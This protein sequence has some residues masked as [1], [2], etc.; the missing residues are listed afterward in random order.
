[1]TRNRRRKL[2]T[3]AAAATSD[4]RFTQARRR[5]LEAPGAS[6]RT[7]RG[8]IGICPTCGQPAYDSTRGASHFA[9]QDGAV[10]CPAFPA[11]AGVLRMNWDDFSL[12]Q[13][14]ER[15]PRTDEGFRKQHVD[16][17]HGDQIQTFTG[18]VVACSHCGQ[19]A[20]Y[21]GEVGMAHFLN[22]WDG[23]FCPRFPLAGETLT[24]KWHPRS[25]ADWKAGYSCT[26][27]HL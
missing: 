21:N 16:L 18:R 20:Y 12:R 24:I 10:F 23:V 19:P 22:Q 17:S 26:F 6:I 13:V 7:Y 2:E 1:M 3:R 11:A 15:Y 9:E 4:I 8:D 5:A 25:L 14:R 27:P